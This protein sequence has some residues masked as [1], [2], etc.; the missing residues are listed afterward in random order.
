LFNCKK[1]V[2]AGRSTGWP[3]FFPGSATDYRKPDMRMWQDIK[4]E[5]FIA[6]TASR[7]DEHI[8]FKDT[9]QKEIKLTGYSNMK[10]CIGFRV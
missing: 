5:W 4:F 9:N 7:H 2:L 3:A 10:R 6:A 1:V 8:W